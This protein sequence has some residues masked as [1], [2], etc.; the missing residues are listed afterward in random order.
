MKFIKD[1]KARGEDNLH[2]FQYFANEFKEGRLA[3]FRA[4]AHDAAALKEYDGMNTAMLPYFGVTENDNWLLTYPM[5]QVAVNSKVNE[6][7]EKEK[8]VMNILSA[9]FSKEGQMKA[10]CDIA[11]LSYN[12]TVDIAPTD[13]MKYII[14]EIESNHLYM[15][16]ASTE[17]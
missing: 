9:M 17:M 12:K 8:A 1:T 16:L 7:P 13:V 5:F 10:A 6:D 3:I 14:P 2:N 4:T 11:F 15:R